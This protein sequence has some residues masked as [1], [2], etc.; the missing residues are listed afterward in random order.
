MDF[1]KNPSTDFKDIDTMSRKQAEEEIEALKEGIEYHNFLYYV[2]NRPEISD[3]VYDRLFHRLQQL[4]K[5]FPEL[6][7]PD[8]PTRRVGAEPVSSLKKVRHAAPMLSLHAALAEKEIERFFRFAQEN[9][10]GGNAALVTEP[11]FDGVSIEVV[12]EKGTF[13]CGTTRGDGETGEDISEN[14][15]TVHSIPLRLQGGETPSKLAIR[16]E[17]FMVKKGFH[18]LNRERVENGEEPFANPR[19]AA[20]GLLRQLDSKKIAGRPLDVRFYRILAME[21]AMEISSHWDVLEQFSRWGLKTDSHNG[22]CTSV[23]EIKNT[24][25]KLMDARDELDYEIDGLVIKIDDLALRERLGTRQRSPRWAM[26]WKFPPKEK[27]SRIEDIVIQ[28]GRTGKLTPVALLQPVDVGGVTISRATLHNEDEV[29][30]KDIRAGDTVR[31]ARAGDVIPEVVERVE[32]P[33]RKRGKS[34]GMPAACPACGS[35]VKRE[36]AYHF[37]TAGL[38]CPPQLIGRI[39]HFAS[40]EALDIEGLNE[41]TAKQLVTR[42]MVTDLADLYRLSKNDLLKLE[43]FAEKSAG[44]LHDAIHSA[45]QPR[46]DRFIYALGIRH[47]GAHI[48]QV[49]ARNVRTLKALRQA[50]KD[51]LQALSEIGPETAASIEEFFSEEDNRKVLERLLDSGFAV[52][53][54]PKREGPLSLQGKTFVFTGSLE[55]YTRNEA[56]RRVASLGGRAA[57]GVSGETDFVVAGEKPGGKLDEA[58]KYGIRILD[59]P[60]FEKL[61]SE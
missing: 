33:G 24:Y 34:F 28:V 54:M 4:E 49:V 27:I 16:G 31:V 47:V 14:L 1:R 46:L 26:A 56:E 43:G 3:A 15:K 58:K 60:E 22:K 23:E 29:R 11:K 41:K 45:A 20:A 39:V 40:R 59:E 38:S 55:K 50:K 37:C 5:A 61:T 35:T 10:P 36:G 32:Q 30:R 52:R 7:S 44:Q 12:Y 53:A 57:S 51:Q 48:A 9:T 19:N 2:K 21:N 42:G 25:R 17:V 8:S 6:E 18:E 13:A